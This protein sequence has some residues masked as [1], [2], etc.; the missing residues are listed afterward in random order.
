MLLNQCLLHWVLG[1][2]DMAPELLTSVTEP[3]LAAL[4]VSALGPWHWATPL[5]LLTSV[6]GTSVYGTVLCMLRFAKNV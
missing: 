1:I 6:Y 3:V 5:E 2:G 4:G